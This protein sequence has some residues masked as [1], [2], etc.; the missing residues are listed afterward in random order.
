MTTL[1]V[2]EIA[3]NFFSNLNFRLT[4]PG[5]YGI[6]GKNGAGKSTFFSILN[7]EINLKNGQVIS[8]KV[9]YIPE[10]DIFDRNLTGN[11]YLILLS[12][13]EKKLFKKYLKVMGGANF[14]NKKIGKYSLGMK[15]LFAFVYLLA[16]KGEVII[17]DELIDGLDEQRRF[18]AYSL[19][20]ECSKDRIILLTSHNLSEV[21]G[22]CDDVFLLENNNLNIIPNLESAKQKLVN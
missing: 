20:R 2:K 13:E 18:V 15:E 5:L 8:G 1:E 11:D 14:L 9:N 17:L 16:L 12:S 7:G 19:L 22:F 6:I 4:E 10:L 3:T 21:F